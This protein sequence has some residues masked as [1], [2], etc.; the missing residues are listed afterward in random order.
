MN[1]I[2][3]FFFRSSLSLREG[4]VRLGRT[5]LD[6]EFMSITTT[7]LVVSVNKRTNNKVTHSKFANRR[8]N[9]NSG[10]VGGVAPA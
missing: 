5:P 3:L 9:N 7:D 8:N 10:N 6:H 4:V 1:D 2:K